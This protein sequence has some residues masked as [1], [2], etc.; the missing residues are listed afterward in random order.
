MLTLLKNNVFK[1]HHPC[2]L[3]IGLLRPGITVEEAE[4]DNPMRTL[5]EV[6][7]ELV[8]E[9]D[10]EEDDDEGDDCEEEEEEEEEDIKVEILFSSTSTSPQSTVTQMTGKTI[11]ICN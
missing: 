8:G 3:R 5:G 7:D 11:Q 6:V 2:I 10:D 1:N 9:D 4:D